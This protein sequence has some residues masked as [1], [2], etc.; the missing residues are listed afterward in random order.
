MVHRQLKVAQVAEA[1]ACRGDRA[2]WGSVAEGCMILL[3]PESVTAP[4]MAVLHMCACVPRWPAA[5]LSCD[6]LYAITAGHL[7]KSDV[8]VGRHTILCEQARV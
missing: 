2:G 4:Q 6:T 8:G 5:T 3:L 7:L 1:A